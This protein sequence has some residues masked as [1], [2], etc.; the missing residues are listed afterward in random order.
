[1][2]VISL[3]GGGSPAAMKQEIWRHYPLGNKVDLVERLLER[4]VLEQHTGDAPRA[5]TRNRQPGRCCDMGCTLPGQAVMVPL[6]ER[7]GA[8][9]PAE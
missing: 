6:P 8:K 3:H 4:G 5:I 9:G 2:S 7:P 1:M